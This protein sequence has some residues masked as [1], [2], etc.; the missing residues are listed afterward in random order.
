ADWVAN[1]T[2]QQKLETLPDSGSKQRYAFESQGMLWME[3][4]G[5]VSTATQKVKSAA[6]KQC[7]RAANAGEE[8]ITTEPPH[9]KSSDRVNKILF[10]SETVQK[11][12][13]CQ[14]LSTVKECQ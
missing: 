3:C 13:G 11:A 7:G 14:A 5:L 4:P 12:L 1:K 2:L 6:M 10:S 8:P 9:P